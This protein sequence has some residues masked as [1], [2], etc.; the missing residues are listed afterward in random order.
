VGDR[1]VLKA[2][3]VVI[4]GGMGNFLGAIFASLLLGIVEGLASAYISAEYQDLFGF[5]MVLLILVFRPY[6]LFGR[7]MKGI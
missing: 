7:R 3:V 2:F 4:M 6:G 5:V 1:V